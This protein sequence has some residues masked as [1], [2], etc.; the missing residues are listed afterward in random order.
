MQLRIASAR[1]SEVAILLV[2][3][4]AKVCPLEKTVEAVKEN[5]YRRNRQNFKQRQREM[6]M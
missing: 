6:G 3:F 2:K 4:I 1:H 5:W